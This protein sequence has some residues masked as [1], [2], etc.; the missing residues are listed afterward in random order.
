MEKK[1]VVE[2]LKKIKELGP[3]RKHQL[4]SYIT[5]HYLRSKKVKVCALIGPELM[6]EAKKNCDKFISADDFDIVSKD[7]KALKKIAREYDYFIAQANIMPKVAGSFGRVLG[8]KGKMPNPKV[9]QMP[10]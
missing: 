2:A 5:L 1:D 8:P 7:K 3:K 6:E 9:L 4:D 10:T